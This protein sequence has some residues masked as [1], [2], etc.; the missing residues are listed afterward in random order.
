M[1][2]GAMFLSQI[3]TSLAQTPAGYETRGQFIMQLDRALG[4]QPIHPVQPD[5]RDVPPA[6]P[7]YGYIE[8]AY[9]AGYINGFHPGVFGPNEPITRAEAAKVE[10]LGAGLG[11]EI[12]GVAK[13]S[14]LDNAKI[15]Q[16]LIPYVAVAVKA[17]LLQGFKD[18][19]FH[20]NADLTAAQE[21]YLLT[22]LQAAVTPVSL[23][24]TASGADVL[25]GATVSLSASGLT[26][27]GRSVPVPGVVFQVFGPVGASYTLQGSI[28]SATTTGAYRI[29]ATSGS[30]IGSV[31]IIVSSATTATVTPPASRVPTTM[32]VTGAG[33]Y[34]ADQGRAGITVTAVV[35]D[36]NGLPL[37]DALIDFSIQGLS[38][39]VVSTPILTDQNGEAT[40]RLIGT[41][42]GTGSVTAT[43][44]GTSVAAQSGSIVIGAGTLN[45]L[46]AAALPALSGSPDMVTMTA[47]DAY[48][49]AING[50]Y[51]VEVA[52]VKPSTSP[53]QYGTFGGNPISGGTGTASV[54]F[55]NGTAQVPLV[56][57]AIA[58]DSLTFSV[59]AVAAQPIWVVVTASSSAVVTA[60]VPPMQAGVSTPIQISLHAGTSG[61]SGLYDVSVAGVQKAPNGS[62]GSFDGV[63][64]SGSGTATANAVNFVSGTAT[65][66]I[67]LDCAAAQQLQ[68]TV[69]QSVSNPISIAVAPGSVQTVTVSPP[70][71]VITAGSG[72]T[73]TLHASDAYGN[74]LVGPHSVGI[75]GVAVAPNGSYGNFAGAIIQGTPPQTGTADVSAVN[76]TAGSAT[77]SVALSSAG[78]HQIT[79]SVDGQTAPGTSTTVTAGAPASV[80][81]APA[82]ST[83]AAGTADAIGLQ[84]TDQYGNPE[85]GSYSVQVSGVTAAPDGTDYG[86]ISAGGT[87]ASITP[88]GASLGSVAF[89][90][91][92][93]SV[94]L[95][96]D[97]AGYT[98]PV[99]TVGGTASGGLSSSMVVTAGAPNQ[100]TLVSPAAN[101]TS[102]IVQPFTLQ[103]QDKYQNPVSGTETVSVSGASAAPAAATDYGTLDGGAMVS[104]SASDS[105]VTFS[106][107]AGTVQL[108]LDDAASQT[109]AFAVGGLSAGS[110]TIAV[111][112]GP[113]VGGTV[114]LASTA[115]AGVPT[116]VSFSG[117][118]DIFGNLV[119][120][121]QNVTMSGAV[122]PQNPADSDSFGGTAVAAGTGTATATFASGATASGI[123][124][125][126]EAAGR[127]TLE[128]G[129]GGSP[130]A[131][132]SV[133]VTPGPL[134]II[135]LAGQQGPNSTIS[136]IT[137][138]SAVQVTMVAQ[139][140]YGNGIAGTQSVTVAGALPAPNGL[141]GTIDGSTI[142]KASGVTTGTATIS[143][144][145]A[146]AQTTSVSTTLA[147]GLSAAGT[148]ITVVAPTT[149]VPQ[150][151]FTATITPGSGT[152]T[153]SAQAPETV[154]VTAIDST[155]NTW[156]VTR[157]V[158]SA[159]ST[160]LAAPLPNSATTMVIGSAVGLPAA[161]FYVA[162]SP[163]TST[164]TPPGQP[165]EIVEVTA[166]DTATNSLTVVRGQEGT[167]AQTW[168]ADD[169]VVVSGE[170]WNT[171]DQITASG[172]S[173]VAGVSAPFAL[174]LDGAGSQALQYSV[175]T[176]SMGSQT[177]NVSAGAPASLTA[178]G[179]STATHGASNPYSVTLTLKDSFGNPI[180][181]TLSVAATGETG[182]GTMDGIAFSSGG[183]ATDPSVAFGSGGQ[184]TVVLVFTA[185]G[186][187]NITFT[188]Q[189]VSG[190]LATVTVN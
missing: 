139:D 83:V 74:A 143:V 3:G 113:A 122:A 77:V 119:T 180:S 169:Q 189:G 25:P 135:R 110:A 99:F 147:S 190:T 52:G 71:G 53:V 87:Q 118:K 131:S 114:S 12:A 44:Q 100:A 96:I 34:T 105:S 112:S 151:P 183:S 184:A 173:G 64:V 166:V 39:A 33:S 49:N 98:A 29:Q 45:T 162:I 50:S 75:S 93:A 4:I 128:F 157:G 127:Q 15:P 18:G 134:A 103:A 73:W 141:Y 106:A 167:T 97:A 27:T 56:L 142:S 158:S 148:Q 28:F 76:F 117:V 104:G 37:P 149:T 125:T 8:A 116:T 9:R 32:D 168:S 176:V 35:L 47:T 22:Q 132:T 57:D 67:Q 31:T 115:T 60:S 144:A 150:L 126:L 1:I 23:D 133:N 170:V 17:G 186:T 188:V 86:S 172:T 26:G 140:Q 24:V 136:T 6:N 70:S 68:F 156:T 108:A 91:G 78:S 89:T 62:Y 81:A 11:K 165:R 46:S 88:G 137:A 123:P 174:T 120:G 51:T 187:E 72:A 92:L 16:K 152:G 10:V 124:L 20:P 109:L 59:G 94:S 163:G 14:F 138:G 179:S 130:I 160:T 102:G 30:I 5:F 84:L 85:S 55:V 171:G 146:P 185:A 177:F 7:Y 181:G 38:G 121:S 13:T 63:A 42:G 80:S 58:T 54:T 40:S 153:P 2:C 154:T 66:S 79:F 41:V 43:V 129:V 95:A 145:F 69:G 21:T 48:G 161:P 182:G 90:G 61:V 159:A 175:G 155:T 111:G 19:T 107:G 65:L 82:I 164:G 36:Q 178:L 101:M